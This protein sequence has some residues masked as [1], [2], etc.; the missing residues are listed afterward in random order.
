MLVEET[1]Q[2]IVSDD[3]RSPI[4]VLDSSR[5]LTDP[6]TACHHAMDS[7]TALKC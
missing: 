1:L 4:I 2:G 7:H 6:Q 3:L 5:F